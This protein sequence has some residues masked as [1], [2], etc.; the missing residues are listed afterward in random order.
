MDA[1]PEFGIML[2]GIPSV[3]GNT[4]GIGLIVVCK[5]VNDTRQPDHGVARFDVYE[6]LMGLV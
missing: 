1:H 5:P 6:V 3:V 2:C 4:C